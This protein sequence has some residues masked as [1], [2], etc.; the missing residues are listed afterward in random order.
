MRVLYHYDA[1]PALRRRL[2]D[3]ADDGMDVVVC[4][5]GD[6]GRFFELLA[7][8]EVLWHCLRPVDAEV[9]AAAP[10]LRLVQKIGV[11]V[12]TIDLECARTRDIAVCNLPGSNARAVAEHTL[13][14]M[15]ALL[16]RLRS[17]ETLT[18]SGSGW[19]RDPSLE[20][21]LGELA[22]RTVGLVGHGAVPRALIPVLTALGADVVYTSRSAKPDSEARRL[23]FEALLAAADVVSLH[24]PLTP[25]TARMMDAEAFARLR[26]GALLVNTARGGLV[27]ETALLAALDS[28]R[29]AGAG[30]DVFDS[31]PLPADHPLLV[32]DDVVVTPHVAWLT[33]ETLAR[34]VATAAENCRRLAASE[35]LLHRIV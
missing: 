31:E 17:F 6:D 29:L 34:S 21:G 10:R 3:L 2:A 4:S 8:T 23:S 33:Q 32:R 24:V 12:N 18:R 26:R 1:G 9:F 19:E 22:G 7:D 28:G 13:L 30:L 27:D 20:D 11:G 16:R 5:E 35:A 25:E 14:L 15:L